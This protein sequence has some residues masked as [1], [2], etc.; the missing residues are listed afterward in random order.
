MTVESGGRL[1][2]SPGGTYESLYSDH[3]LVKAGG[4]KY[5][6]SSRFHLAG[7]IRMKIES[8]KPQIRLA[9]AGRGTCLR[10][11]RCCQIPT[12]LFPLWPARRR[13]AEKGV[14]CF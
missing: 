11:G 8:R 10:Q 13:T 5:E 6:I 7:G 9:K 4:A 3:I 1:S 14:P 12:A 2:L